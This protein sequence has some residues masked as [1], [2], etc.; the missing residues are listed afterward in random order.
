M[1]SWYESHIDRQI[2]EAQERGEFDDLPGAGRPLP[3]H[4]ELYD[5]DWW[6]RDLARRERLP[7]GIPPTL[8]LRREVEDLPDELGNYR[9]EESLRRAV[10]DLNTR[11][12]R[13]RRG[14]IEGPATLLRPLDADAIV[15]AWR[16]RG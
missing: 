8:R 2:R 14:L 4:G 7:G 12:E 11:I 15:E 10:A 6:I 9:T 1:T 13:A 16:N 5:E 3:D